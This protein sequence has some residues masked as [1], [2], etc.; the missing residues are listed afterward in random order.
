[1]NDELLP[2]YV[3][4]KGQRLTELFDQHADRDLY[5]AFNV[6]PHT[7]GAQAWITVSPAN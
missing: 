3:W 4:M 5:S 6:V 2:G 7:Q 1:L